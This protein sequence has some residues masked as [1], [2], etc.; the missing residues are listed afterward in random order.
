MDRQ[1]DTQHPS[2]HFCRCVSFINS[3]WGQDDLAFVSQIE[4]RRFGQLLERRG[5]RQY[6]VLRYFLHAT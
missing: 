6:S 4:R 5:W 1:K 2:F 3:L